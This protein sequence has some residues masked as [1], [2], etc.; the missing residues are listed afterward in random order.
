MDAVNEAK[1]ITGLINDGPLSSADF[2]VFFPPRR[3]LLPTTRLGPD[4]T[5]FGVGL[6]SETAV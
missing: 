2:C 6:T 5:G 3:S 4:A 1:N